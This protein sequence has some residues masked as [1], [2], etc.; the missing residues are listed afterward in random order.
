[1]G[2]NIIIIIIIYYIIKN[3]RYNMSVEFIILAEKNQSIEEMIKLIT[4]FVIHRLIDQSS[5]L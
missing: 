2:Q 5:A 4:Y 3:Y 1:M